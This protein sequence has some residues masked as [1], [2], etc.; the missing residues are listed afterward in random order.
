MGQLIPHSSE[1]NGDLISHTNHE[2]YTTQFVYAPEHYL[3]DIIDPRGIHSNRYEYDEDGS[4]VALIDAEDNR[5]QIRSSGSPALRRSTSPR[6]ARS[7][8]SDSATA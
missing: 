5:T 3:V 8:T 7:G 6:R 1:S 4:L 2:E